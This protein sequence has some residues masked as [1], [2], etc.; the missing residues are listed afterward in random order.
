MKSCCTGCA[1]NIRNAIYT[2]CSNGLA[3]GGRGNALPPSE[4]VLVP[5]LLL[6]AF[7]LAIL[8]GVWAGSVL[9]ANC[10]CSSCS[11]GLLAGGK[12][13]GAIEDEGEGKEAEGG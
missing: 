1:S 6:A 3:F 12:G 4:W 11:R 5:V 10:C 13:S 9:A 2:A 8:C 7:P